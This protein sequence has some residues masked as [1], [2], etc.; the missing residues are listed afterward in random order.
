MRPMNGILNIRKEPGWTS[1]DVVAKLRRILGQKRIGHTGTLDPDAEG[2]LPV[3]LG[4]ATRAADMLTDQ[5]K[6]YEAGASAGRRNRY[7]RMPGERFWTEERGCLYP[8]R[9]VGMCSL[10]FLGEQLQIPPMYS[11]LKKDGKKLYE[12]AREGKTVEREP[13]KGAFL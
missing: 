5:T 1:H 3:C 13:R 7:P 12:L 8:R 9:T 6:T 4:K 2:V 11:A 10:P